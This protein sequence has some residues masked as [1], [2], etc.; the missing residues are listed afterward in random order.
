MWNRAALMEASMV[1]FMVAAWYCYVRAQTQPLLGRGSR[2]RA[3]CSRSSPRPRRCSS[4]RRSALEALLVLVRPDGRRHDRR[5]AAGRPSPTLAGLA[6]CGARRARGLRAAE[7]DRL[8]LLQLADVGDAQAGY[9]LRVAARTASRGFRSS[10][11]SSRACGSRGRRRRGGCSGCWRA[12]ATAPPASGCSCCGSGS[13][14]SSCSSTTSA[15][16]AA[17]C[18]S[19][20]RW[21]RWRRI[22][23]GRD[24]RA[25]CRSARARSPRATALAGAA[26]RLL[27]R[28]TSSSARSSRLAFLYEVRPGVRLAR[29]ARASLCTVAR[30]RHVAA[31]AAAAVAARQW[32]PRGGVCSSRRWSSAG[33]LAQFAQWARDRTYKNYLASVELGRVLPPGTLVHGKLA[34][35]LV[36]REPHQADLRRPRVRQLRRPEAARRCA[37]YFDLRRAV[38][39]LREDR[40]IQ[41]VL[42][43]YPDR[44]IIMTFDVAE[45]ATGHDRAALID[46]FGGRPASTAAGPGVR[47]IDE[48]AIKAHADLRFRSEY[49]YALF[50]YYRSAKVIAF[51]ERAGVD[52]SRAACSTPAAAAA[53]CRCRSPK[54][55]ALV[56]GIDPGG[57]VPGR[58]RPARPR[59]RPAATCTSRWPTAWPCPF[60]DRHVRP[61][62]VARGHRAR[63]RRAA[64]PARVRAGAGAGRARVPVDGAV[65]VVCRRAPAAAEG[66]GAAAPDGRAARRVRDVPVPRAARGRGR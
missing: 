20:R 34:N 53:A 3:R 27:R 43:A 28:S 22:V 11:T 10:T 48:R 41:D 12:G 47:R 55:P 25:R 29:G 6:V 56:V 17:S 16:S 57:A 37:I 63:R 15:T 46:K 52:D 36:A 9:D 30:L 2:P 14:P 42:D 54:R 23:L 7:L 21:S 45:T 5:P 26:A 24:R 49:D 31:A 35:G 64:V 13:A 65:P 39:R 61:G 33:Q 1:A 66:A 18:S 44:T 8:P 50:E 40:V 62:A 19:S 4:S 32:T 51:L 38:P 58:R 59:A 60:R